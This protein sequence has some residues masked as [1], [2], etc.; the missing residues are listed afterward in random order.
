MGI[1]PLNKDLLAS[2]G[3]A[4]EFFTTYREQLR[5]AKAIDARNPMFERAMVLCVDAVKKILFDGANIE[6]E[7]A[8]KE[9]YLRM[10]YYD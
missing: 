6:K 9:Y 10:L 7:L 3:F 4:S 2:E 8:E 5:H 1:L